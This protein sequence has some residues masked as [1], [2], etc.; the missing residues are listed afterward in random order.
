MTLSHVWLGLSG[1]RF[2]SVVA[3]EL[4]LQQLHGDGFHLEHDVAKG[5]QVSFGCDVAK[6]GTP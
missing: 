3:C 2:Q 6:R 5:S 4:Q 1:G